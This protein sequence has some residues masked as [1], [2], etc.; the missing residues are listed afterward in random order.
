MLNMTDYSKF[1]TN[2]DSA[3]FESF[4]SCLNLVGLCLGR[5]VL[6]SYP[7]QM[8]ICVVTSAQDRDHVTLPFK[9]AFD[10][11]NAQITISSLWNKYLPPKGF[12]PGTNI[13]VSQHHDKHHDKHH[14][15]HPSEVDLMVSVSLSLTENATI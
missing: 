9:T 15:E 12:I 2:A 14:D 1:L 11:T 8:K 3:G 10:G 4:E 5:Q 6:A 13:L 7:D